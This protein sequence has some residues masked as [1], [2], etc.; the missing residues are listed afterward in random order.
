MELAIRIALYK[1]QLQSNIEPD[2]TNLNIPI[3]GAEFRERVQTCC[4]DQSA[5]LPERILRSIVETVVDENTTDVHA[6]RIGKGGNCPQKMRGNDKAQ[7]RDIDREFH[8][9]YWER[10][11]GKIELAS[12]VYHN[13]FEI[14][15]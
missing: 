7:R 11:D 5:T 10:S 4:R 13:D 1:R 3:V 12:V 6:L 14:P 8:L 15:E 9:H 2:W